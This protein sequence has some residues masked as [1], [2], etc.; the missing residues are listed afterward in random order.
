MLTQTIDKLN[1]FMNRRAFLGTTAAASL[2]AAPAR[3]N[4]ILILADDLGYGDLGCTGHPTIRT[5]HL[6][7]M[8]SE[9]MRLT[10]YYS[11][12][13]LCSP[14]R[15]SLLTGRLHA[16]S[17]INFVLFPWSKGGL[18]QSEITI[19]RALKPAGYATACIGK[20]HLG[21][22]SPHLPMDHGFDSW[23]GIPYS[24]D[25]SRQTNIDAYGVRMNAG[26]LQQR[27]ELPPIPLMRNKDILEREP[28]QAQLT[29][30]YTDEA[31]RFMKDARSRRQPY[32]LYLPHTFPHVPLHT[33]PQQSGRSLRGLY[34]D[35]V[36]EL[37]RSVGALLDHLRSTRQD[38]NT[39]VL[40]T[41]DN[42]PA[43]M[44][45]AGKEGTGGSAGPF[46]DFKGTIWEGGVREPFLA[47]WPGR[48]PA[49]VVNPAFAEANDVFPT[50][51]NTASVP[52]PT[53]RPYD[54]KDLSGV[55]L[56]GE[57]G[58]E[59][60]HYYYAGEKAQAI[61]VGPWKLHAPN[62]N[63]PA[64]LFHL[65]NDIS[66]R[67]DRAAEHPDVLARLQQ[68]IEEH[69]SSFTPPPSVR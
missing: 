19:A 38:R 62:N 28:D 23:F 50:I 39:L 18:P 10:Q 26:N 11:A 27:N 6:D 54:G 24:N 12:N 42:G 64:Q 69:R 53:D 58:R 2:L 37:D 17:G 49:G 16:R 65:E 52:L 15:A 25:M 7:R 45:F 35:T 47:W 56:R 30:R 31:L 63:K 33:S 40:F 61:R 5:P 41:S 51:L 48:I 46:R 4:I 68:K 9:G 3:P 55:L 66:E 14:S 43:Q 59:A 67:F 57:A 22:E 1:P 8:A 21:H 34:G 44:N 60:L 36:E 13:P 32:F 29:T 20:W